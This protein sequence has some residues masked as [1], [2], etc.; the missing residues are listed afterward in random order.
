MRML[1]SGSEKGSK[2]DA[3]WEIRKRV[4]AGSAVRLGRLVGW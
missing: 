3:G 1:Q 2:T 4:S